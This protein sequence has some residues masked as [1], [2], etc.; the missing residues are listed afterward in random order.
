MAPPAAVAHSAGSQPPADVT[1]GAAS[2]V[3]SGKQ[4]R[5]LHWCQNNQRAVLGTLGVITLIVGWELAART[6]LLDPQFTSSPSRIIVAGIDYFTRDTGLADIEVTLRTFATGFVGAAIAG[7]LLGLL[8][9]WFRPFESFIEPVFNFAYTSPRPAL[10]PLFV[11][12][13]GIGIESKIALVFVSAIFPIAIATSVGVRTIDRG[14]LN[15]AKSFNASTVQIVRTLVLPSSV[16]HIV[17]GIRVGLGHALTAVI[18]GEMVVANKGIGYSMG[19][20]A[21]TFNVDLVFCGFILVGT[22]GLIVAELLWRVE[23]KLET[24]RP[25]LH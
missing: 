21:N 2:P 7:I 10:F 8:M 23:R 19:V 1:L 14:L 22:I 9:G 6:G 25:D 4:Q 16:P 15:V 17:S 20:A 13:F 5:L 11:I 12:W 3:R 18:F 24:W